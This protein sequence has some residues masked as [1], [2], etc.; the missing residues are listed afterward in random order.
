[1]ENNLNYGVVG[2]CRTAALVSERGTIEWMCLPDFD[3]PSVFARCSTVERRMLR[4]RRRGRLCFRQATSR[5]PTSSR[6]PSRRTRASSRCSTS[7]PATVRSQG[8]TLHAGGTLPLRPVGEGAAPLP[9]TL[10]PCAR[11]MPAARCASP[12]ARIHRELQ[13][14]DNKDRQYLYA[15]LP[16]ASRRRREEI[17][18]KRTNSCCCR[19]TKKSFR[20]TSNAKRSNIAARW[21]TGSTGPTAPTRFTY[22]NDVVERSLLVLKLL[23]YY[24]GAVLAALTTSLPETV[25][26]SATGITV[27]AGSAMP[28]CPSRRCFASDTPAP[29]GGS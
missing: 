9:R 17:A 1:M 6:R 3:S 27:S 5:T 29:H 23:S 11:T 4:I 19:T 24:N 2:N 21:S 26:E 16:L 8:G 22:Y 15:S 12:D 20:S 28:R 10:R 18:S 7:C 14:P 25:G 13:L